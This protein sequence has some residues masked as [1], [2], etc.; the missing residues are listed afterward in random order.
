MW[1]HSKVQA[2][3]GTVLSAFGLPPSQV[4]V[5]PAVPGFSG[6]SVWRVIHQGHEYALKC[7]PAGQPALTPLSKIH[8]LTE[9]AR[10]TGLDFIPAVQWTT[11]GTSVVQHDLHLWD[12][13]SWQHGSPLSET[14][15]SKLTNAVKS[16][17]QLHAI[18]RQTNGMQRQFCPAVH[19]QHQ[20]LASWSQEELQTLRQMTLNKELLA[21]ASELFI[22]HRPAALIR[23]EAWLSRTVFVHYCVGDIWSDHVL[24]TGEKVTGLIDFGGMRLD[25]PAQ[26]L[27]RLLGS[28]SQGCALIRHEALQAYFPKSEE[29]ETLVATLDDSGTVVALGNWLRWVLLENRIFPD[30]NRV[31]MRMQLLVKRLLG[32]RPM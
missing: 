1:H 17:A 18:W 30:V 9:Q 10:R 11:T 15:L 23:L 5:I 14:S 32:Q 31:V 7:W 22:Q 3:L 29:L 20:R 26:D 4:Q 12:L 19:L 21:T 13:C 8:E 2:S 25:H 28:F 6:A 27:A 16:L 24:F